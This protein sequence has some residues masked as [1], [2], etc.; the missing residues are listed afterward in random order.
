[1]APLRAWAAMGTRCGFYTAANWRGAETEIYH[2]S[3]TSWSGS[4]KYT[5][6]GLRGTNHSPLRYID[7][8]MRGL[9][10]LMATASQ[11]R[12]ETQAPAAEGEAATRQSEHINGW[13]QGG[14]VRR[15]G[16]G[17][18]TDGART[19]IRMVTSRRTVP[20]L[21]MIHGSCGRGRVKVLVF[22]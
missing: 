15:G 17:T 12:P 4:I 3:R 13:K 18:W 7:S 16:G 14:R 21:P 20:R 6:R 5:A 8:L 11:A 2:P 10:K 1:M 19:C 9:P 22:A